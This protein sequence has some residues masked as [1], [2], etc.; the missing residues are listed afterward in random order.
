VVD[1]PFPLGFVFGGTVTSSVGTTYNT[2]FQ[3]WNVPTLAAGQSVTMTITFFNLSNAAPIKAFAQVTACTQLD[4][5]STPN[6]NATTTP[7]ED[8]EA[9]V[10]ITSATPPPAEI[11]ALTR[12][13]EAQFKPIVVQKI[14]P[15][16]VT[17]NSVSV[18]YTSIVEKDVTFEFWNQMGHLAKAETRQVA[19]GEQTQEFDLS[20]LPSGMYILYV[21]SNSLRGTPM[22]IVKQ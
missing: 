2:Y 12:R 18:T 6:N 4:S 15:V 9:A 13:M 21:S 22:K 3:K 10:T 17:E 1:F 19:K 20:E 8:D 7:V 5:D 14:F 16:P 11:A